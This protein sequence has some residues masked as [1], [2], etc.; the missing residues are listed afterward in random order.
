MYKS[1]IEFLIDDACSR[2]TYD[3]E[4]NAWRAVQKVGIR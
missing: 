1:S 3:A 4:E 2:I